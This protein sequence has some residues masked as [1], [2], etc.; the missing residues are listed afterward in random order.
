MVCNI[1]I[2]IG[3]DRNSIQCFNRI[4]TPFIKTPLCT[5]GTVTFTANSWHGHKMG[6]VYR[7]RVKGEFVSLM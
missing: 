6:N 1:L 5:H 2:C 7:Q 4:M 3:I